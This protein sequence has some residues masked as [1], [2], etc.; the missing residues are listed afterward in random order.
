MAAVAPVAAA[1][2]AVVVVTA[3]AVVVVAQAAVVATVVVAAVAQAAVATAVVAVAAPVAA[4]T[5]LNRPHLWANPQE[6][7][8]P[9]AVARKPTAF[10][11]G[12]RFVCAQI[13]GP[14]APIPASGPFRTPCKTSTPQIRQSSDESL[15]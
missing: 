6:G 11:L 14:A 4:V 1:L 3:A 7:L 9:S 15:P 8:H 13:T 12:D 10:S 2:A 5:E